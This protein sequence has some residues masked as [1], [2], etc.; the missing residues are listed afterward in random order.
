M[1]GSSGSSD[2]DTRSTGSSGVRPKPGGGGGDS[3]ADADPC[4]LEIE[5]ELEGVQVAALAA[6]NESESL[7]I[8]LR[9]PEGHSVVVCERSSGELV[10]SVG[11]IEGLS[12][13]IACLEQRVTYV[14]AVIEK[15]RGRCR[16]RIY[17]EG[18]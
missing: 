10:G 4:N 17:R 6:V 15:G 2:Y 12:T 5:V 11:G 18:Q 16:V 1:G 7:K 8:L 14:G 3:G 13:L 9:S